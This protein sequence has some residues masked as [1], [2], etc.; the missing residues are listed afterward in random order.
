ME[1]MEEQLEKAKQAN[2]VQ[3]LL[4]FAKENGIELTEKEASE[5]FEVLKKNNALTDE[6]LADVSG[7]KFYSLELFKNKSDVNYLFKVGDIVEVKNWF[8]VGTVRCRITGVRTEWQ[9]IGGNTGGPGMVDGDCQ[10]EGWA[11]SYYCQELESHWYFSNG[12]CGRDM[13]EI[14]NT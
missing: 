7:G 11:D 10:K 8:L 13:L 4:T 12:W 9:V 6:E 3:E 5:H 2:N 1:L 14:P